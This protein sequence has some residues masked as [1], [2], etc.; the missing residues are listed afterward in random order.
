M[1]IIYTASSLS[2]RSVRMTIMNVRTSIYADP[3]PVPSGYVISFGEADG[4]PATMSF[5]FTWDST[6]NS[7]HAITSYRV[8]PTNNGGSSVVECP[9]SC[10]PDVPCRCI[11]L[12]VGDQ[13]QVNLSAIN[14]DTQE[15]LVSM[16]TIAS[17]KF[18]QEY[19]KKN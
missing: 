5:N 11:G 12:R 3:P 8:V 19:I 7:R 18:R 6:F 14:C 2:L 1:Y 13:E 17:C 15:G 16:V 10:P 9:S 4:A